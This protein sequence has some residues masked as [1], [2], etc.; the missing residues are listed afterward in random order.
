MVQCRYSAWIEQSGYHPGVNLDRIDTTR[1]ESANVETGGLQ[2]DLITGQASD[3]EWLRRWQAARTTLVAASSWILALP[4]LAR[5]MNWHQRTVTWVQNVAGPLSGLVW[6]R[7]GWIGARH[8]GLSNEDAFLAGGLAGVVAPTLSLTLQRLGWPPGSRRKG[9]TTDE[10]PPLF[11]YPLAWFWGF[12]FGGLIAALG[13][14][15]A[16][17]SRD[18]D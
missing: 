5:L 8:Y 6:G 14:I 13:A 2:M 1:G 9:T 16:R 17:L 18:W 3:R 15:A 4:V 12:L 7:I 11:A 10:Q